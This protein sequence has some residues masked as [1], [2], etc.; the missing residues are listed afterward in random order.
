M[1]IIGKMPLM[2]FNK[3]LLL[4]IFSLS[5]T[6][7]FFGAALGSSFMV[8]STVATGASYA[9]SGKGLTDHAMS[10]IADKDCK[11]FNVIDGKSVC[12]EYKQ[13][14]INDKNSRPESALGATVQ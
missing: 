4:T 14:P 10:E 9:V 7:C 3:T 2:N 6:G 11:M 12:Q 1:G 8:Q 13:I 5:Q